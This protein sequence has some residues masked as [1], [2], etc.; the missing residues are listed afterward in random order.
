MT[1]I[2]PREFNDIGELIS[3]APIAPRWKNEALSLFLQPR[4]IARILAFHHLYEQILPLHGEVMEFG[5]AHGRDMNILLSLRRLL[6]PSVPRRIIGFDTFTGVPEEDIAH[7]KGDGEKTVPGYCAT[8]GDEYVEFLDSWLS[9]HNNSHP[10][11]D[12]NAVELHVGKVQ[13]TLPDWLEN[14]E[15]PIA[16]A[17]IDYTA[18][19]PTIDT[20]RLIEERLVPGAIVGFNQF[21]TPFHQGE[22]RALRELGW[23]DKGDVL[24]NPMHRYWGTWRKNR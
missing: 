12:S 9:R 16:L 10:S 2:Q 4:D 5:V 24:R 13:E 7:D 23:M 21:A 11:T 15:H 3:A 14:N 8:I 18:Y 17:F 6:E 19:Q 22:A 20:M 1:D